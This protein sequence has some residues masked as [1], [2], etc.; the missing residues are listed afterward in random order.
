MLDAQS[1][2]TFQRCKRWYVFRE[3]YLPERWHPKVLFD[4]CLR[5]AIFLLSNGEDPKAA[6]NTA[7]ARYMSTA[8]DR[9]LDVIGMNPYRVAQDYT[10]ML[11]TI[12]RGLAKTELMCVRVDSGSPVSWS[13]S[14]WTDDTGTLHRWVT[15]AK[16][17]EDAMAREAHSWAT[18]GDMAVADAPMVLHAIEIGYQKNGRHGAAWSRAFKHPSLHNLKPHFRRRDGKNFQGWDPIYLA[19]DSRTDV[20][21]W[22]NQAWEEGALEPLIHD[23]RWKMLS[24][25]NR[26][27]TLVQIEQVTEEIKSLDGKDWQDVPMSRPACDGFI[28]CAY[29]PVCYGG[30]EKTLRENYVLR[31]TGSGP[32]ARRPATLAP[33]AVLAVGKPHG[34]RIKYLGGCRCLLCRAANSRYECDRARL[35]RLGLANGIVDAAPAR[36]H[37]FKLSNVGIYH[38][39]SPKH[40][41]RYVDEFAYRFNT[42]SD[43]F[44]D[45]F[46]QL[47]KN[48]SESNHLS[49]KNLTA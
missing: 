34:T 2:T 15:L 23:I 29:I 12:I 48:V 41:Q 24:P 37:L 16:W 10:A 33:A 11:D 14:S 3:Q 22:V 19:D 26:A 8:A 21:A 20:D 7:K 38:W 44:P 43:V 27:N 25:E 49:Y 47:V 32:L 6:A 5:E 31:G 45:V 40:L 13:L 9:G 30:S 39:M 1:F 17:D 46:S 28:P 36:A 35:R 4:S 42:A 18:V